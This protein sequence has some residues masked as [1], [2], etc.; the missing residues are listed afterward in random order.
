MQRPNKS[1]VF[2]N[3][4]ES[5]E[6]VSYTIPIYKVRTNFMILLSVTGQRLR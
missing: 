5:S 3:F 1:I 4:I 2:T 6:L